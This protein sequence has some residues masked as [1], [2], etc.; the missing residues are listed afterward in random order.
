MHYDIKYRGEHLLIKRNPP[1]P[2]MKRLRLNVHPDSCITLSAP[3]YTTERQIRHFIEAHIDWLSLQF[4]KM[5]QRH[6]SKPQ[7]QYCAGE[8]HYFLGWHYPLTFVSNHNPAQYDM[9]ICGLKP[10]YITLSVKEKNNADKVKQALR[11][12]YKTRALYYFQQ[13]LTILRSKTPWVRQTP[14]L[15]CRRMKRQWGNCAP[16]G[17]ITLNTHLIKAPPK[18]IDYVIHHP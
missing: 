18:C 1:T 7:Y 12:W 5:R 17:H 8:Q 16:K 10:P 15:K 14:L 9:N 13:R 4:T 11:Q 3:K 6:Q 2:R